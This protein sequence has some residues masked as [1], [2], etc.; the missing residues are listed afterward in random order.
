[1]LSLKTHIVG[2]VIGVLAVSGMVSTL[3][4][5]QAEASNAQATLTLQ[6]DGSKQYR[7]GQRELISVPVLLNTGGAAV[8]GV[9][10]SLTYDSR[11][12]RLDQIQTGTGSSLTTYL[13]QQENAVF[14][15]TRIIEKARET[16]RVVFSVLGTDTNSKT[17]TPFNGS[18]LL[19]TLQFTPLEEGTATISW[20]MVAGAT[21][22]TNVVSHGQVPLDILGTANNATLVVLPGISSLPSA[23]PVPTSV[24]VPTNLP[25]TPTLVAST[26]TRV[27]ATATPVPSA[28][29]APSATGAPATTGSKTQRTVTYQISNQADDV[30]EDA[31]F[32]AGSRE[33][34]IGKGQSNASYLGLRF[35]NVTIPKNAEITSAR[36][37]VFSVQQQWISVDVSMGFE[38]NANS[39]AFTAA[40][41]PSKRLLTG[42]TV[43]MADNVRWNNNKW[44]Q[45]PDLTRSLNEVIARPEWSNSNT[46]SLIVTGNG[47]RWGRKQ[48]ASYERN[49]SRAPRLVVTY[50]E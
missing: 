26:P 5:Q 34:W 39:E 14:D 47:S 48:I 37:E 44:Y 3:F 29:R 11:I 13:P 1:M 22:D 46:L 17:V 41:P 19:A 8:I 10:L 12:L 32:V 38:L 27:P 30:Y 36:L 21:D 2:I 43:R 31:S 20:N 28:T 25:A 9:D 49:K 50:R 40:N 18:A 24:P 33:L 6:V 7:I 45:S 42:Y 35:R 15:T 23:T 4:F 16:G